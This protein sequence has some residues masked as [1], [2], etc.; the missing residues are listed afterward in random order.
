M[1]TRHSE[2]PRA[3][4]DFYVEP[5]W[6]PSALFGHLT[7]RGGLHDPCCGIGTIVDVAARHGIAAT[8]ADIA[9]R[10]A[11]R[12]PVRDF[13]T[14]EGIYANVVAN[15]PYRTALPI[16]C[17]ALN[18]VEAGGCVAVLMP[19][20]FLASVRRY[21]LFIRPECE[22]VLVLSRRPSLPPGDLLQRHGESIRGNGSTD[23]LWIALRRGGRIGDHTRIEWATP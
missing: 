2:Q 8:G 17:H 1:S 16:I 23:F 12:F 21:S 6:V 14:D 3:A 20:G 4:G 19:I 5:D 11:G 15:P 22:L 7:L 13:L 18:H 9:D 10:S